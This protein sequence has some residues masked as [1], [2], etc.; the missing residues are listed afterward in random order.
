MTERRSEAETRISLAHL[1]FEEAVTALVRDDDA[2][3]KD[4]PAGES[5]STTEDGPE[6][7]PSD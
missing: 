3:R 1:S 5:C 7:G 4:S 2:T 6:A